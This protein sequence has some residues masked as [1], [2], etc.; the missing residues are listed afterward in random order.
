[1][2]RASSQPTAHARSAP[3]T[4]RVAIL[5][6]IQDRC[7]FEEFAV[8]AWSR[9]LGMV[10]G[11]RRAAVLCLVRRD[12]AR[13]TDHRRFEARSNCAAAAPSSEEHPQPK[14]TRCAKGM[15]I[16]CICSGDEC[17][18]ACRNWHS[19]G[20]ARCMPCAAWHPTHT[21]PSQLELQRPKAKI[22]CCAAATKVCYKMCDAAVQLEGEKWEAFT[23]YP[24]DE[25][26]MRCPRSRP[27]RCPRRRRS[28]R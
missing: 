24:A 17:F 5:L 28:A 20:R 21:R 13:P 9:C 4:W 23:S 1:M 22:N 12:C 7:A 11:D 2:R 6:Q 3:K 26:P 25:R 27:T 19:G 10:E 14:N 8:F 15:C 16:G 18:G